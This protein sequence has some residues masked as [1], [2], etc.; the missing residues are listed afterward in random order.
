MVK[1]N[2]LFFHL[3]FFLCAGI[4]FCAPASAEADENK[5]YAI[6]IYGAE[7]V[8]YEQEESF[9]YV[10]PEAPKG[11]HITVHTSNFNT[12]NPYTLKGM[13]P[14]LM[15]LVFETPTMHSHAEDE[16]FTEYG[17]LVKS[18]ELA[19]D[20]M[21]L[22]YKI[23]ESAQFSDGEPVTADDFVFSFEL[24]REPQYDPRYKQYF[25]GIEDVEKIDDYTV[26]FRF[27]RQNQEVPLLAGQIPILPEHVY[28]AEGKKFA[29]DFDKKAVGSGPYVVED[30]EFGKFIKLRRNPDWWGRDL[31]KA[32]GM[33]NFETITGKVYRTDV[34]RKEAFKGGD[35]DILQVN[36]AKDWALDFRGSYVKNNYIIR[37]NIPHKRPS[38]MQ[39]FVF[40]LRRPVFKSHR[41]RY[42][43]A[44]V[45][46]FEWMN[47]NLFYD[48]YQRLRCFFENSTDMTNVEPPGEKM[49]E[50]LHNLAEKHGEEYV[51]KMTFTEPLQAPGTGK[52]RQLRK[53]QAELL[54]ESA[55]WELGDDG[56]RYKNGRPLEFTLLL[57][58]QTWTR[59]AEPYK[60]WLAEI[61]VKMEVKNIQPAQYQKRVRVF[62]YDMIVHV[63]PHSRSIGNELNSYFSSEAAAVEGSRNVNG[64]QNPVIDEIITEIVGAETRKEL[65]FYGQA[66]DRLLSS[67]T[68]IIP[69]WHLTSDR[70]LSWNKFGRPET[71]CSQLLPEMAAVRYWWYD[72]ERAEELKKKMAA[73]ESL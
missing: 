54:L 37:K 35:F 13:P 59:I 26:R 39:G 20:R 41:T 21:S 48:Q 32:R 34:S 22:V 57:S 43:I 7:G 38:G 67:L 4:L 1:C 15:D 6:S 50:Y 36:T 14:Q 9:P 55:G 42:A 2:T 60:R 11:G 69:H 45:M 19:D 64:V 33:Y 10:Y 40:N 70:F 5:N 51:P 28:G 8:K 17:H 72:S 61:G 16:P 24:T 52:S 44:M 18:I 3:T 65:V 63:F 30:Y 47:K 53:K 23:R 58:N 29:E 66:L 56:M 73:K 49:R 71:H 62:D 25:A 12:L 46:N 68:L 31:A 27:S